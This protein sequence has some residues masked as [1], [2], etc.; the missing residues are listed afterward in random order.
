[1]K[2]LAAA[3]A[4]CAL[5]LGCGGDD[6]NDRRTGT[7]AKTGND[8]ASGDPKAWSPWVG[9][10]RELCRF[11]YEESEK[12]RWRT[13]NVNSRGEA[14]ALLRRL[15]K[16]YR[17]IYTSL[18]YQDPAP[19]AQRLEAN[20]ITSNMR[21]LARILTQ[22]TRAASAG[23]EDRARYLARKAEFRV[24]DTNSLAKQ[25]ALKPCWYQF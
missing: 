14:T 3:A 1:M 5:V 15:A 4:L 25:I 7:A 9:Q 10:A 12:L 2:R 11:Y 20:L 22:A 21:K 23:D 8:S 24:R 13:E 18:N 17:D 6:S 19:A 16:H